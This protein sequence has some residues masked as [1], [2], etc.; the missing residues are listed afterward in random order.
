VAADQRFLVAGPSFAEDAFATLRESP[1]VAQGLGQ[2]F[3]ALRERATSAVRA[4]SVV[5]FESGELFFTRAFTTGY[6][7]NAEL[8]PEPLEH[9]LI[10]T[11]V[12][13]TGAAAGG[14]ALVRAEGLMTGGEGDDRSVLLY[15]HADDGRCAAAMAIRRQRGTI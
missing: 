14:L 2:A 15:G 8:M 1:Q 7:R 3:R 9:E 10:A 12:G 6:L 5:G 13:D 11:Y 4:G